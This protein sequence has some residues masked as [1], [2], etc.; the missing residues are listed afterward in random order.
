MTAEARSRAGIGAN[1]DASLAAAN[2]DKFRS[3]LSPSPFHLDRVIGIAKGVSASS[4]AKQNPG[5]S[6][7]PARGKNQ[8]GHAR[9]SES[10]REV[11]DRAAERDVGRERAY[12]SALTSITMRPTDL[13]SAVISKKTRGRPISLAAAAKLRT[14]V[15]RDVRAV[16]AVAPKWLGC[17]KVES[18]DSRQI[19]LNAIPRY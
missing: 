2:S 9:P 11:R 14:S 15:T 19:D 8:D 7:E 3:R 4:R 13:S 17:L 5:F 16:R 12:V 10:R 18:I 1:R 6:R